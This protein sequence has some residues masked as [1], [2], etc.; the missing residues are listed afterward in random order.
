MPIIS[1]DG[2]RDFLN[3]PLYSSWAIETEGFCAH[4]GVI[5]TEALPHFGKSFIPGRVGI[6]IEATL[7]AIVRDRHAWKG[8]D[9][10]CRS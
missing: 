10:L 9:Q 6:F 1:G 7:R 3:Q 5:A 8:R 2:S 4:F